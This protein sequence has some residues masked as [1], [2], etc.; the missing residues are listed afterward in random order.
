MNST[1]S[2]GFL[3]PLLHEGPRVRLALAAF[4]AL[5]ALGWFTATKCWFVPGVEV[6]RTNT[7]LGVHLPTF[8]PPADD[9]AMLNFTPGG[10]VP[11]VNA[12]DNQKL[13]QGGGATL[14]RADPASASCHAHAALCAGGPNGDLVLVVDGP[15]GGVTTASYAVLTEMDTQLSALRQLVGEPGQ[16]QRLFMVINAHGTTVI[17]ELS[18]GRDNAFLCN[19]SG[20]GIFARWLLVYALLAALLIGGLVYGLTAPALRRF[21]AETWRAAPLAMAVLVLW[22]L[23]MYAITFPGIYVSDSLL[24][25][26]NTGYYTDWFGGLY[27]IVTTLFRIIGYRWMQVLPVALGLMSWL[28]MLRSVTLACANTPRWVRALASVLVVAMVIANPAVV[29]AMFAQ[30]RY[31]LVLAV[32]AA[33]VTLAFYNVIVARIESRPMS[34]VAIGTS[35]TL[36]ALAAL[37]RTEYAAPLLTGVVL[38]LLGYF[39]QRHANPDAWLRGRM[40]I[41]AAL[42]VFFA[43]KDVISQVVP[44]LYHYD[45][46]RYA[47]EYTAATAISFAYPYACGVTPDPAVVTEV[48][49]FGPLDDLCRKGTDYGPENFFWSDIDRHH[50][51]DTHAL[52]TMRRTVLSAVAADWHPYMHQRLRYAWDTATQGPWHLASRYAL[53]DRALTGN[54]GAVS[55][56]MATADQFGLV[57]DWPPAATPERHVIGE[58]YFLGAAIGLYSF[59]VVLAATLA[60]L[61]AGAWL[62][63]AG[64]MTV[65]AMA[66]PVILAEP[67]VDWAYLAFLPVWTSCLLPLALAET[68]TLPGLSRSTVLWLSLVTRLRQFWHFAGL[69]GMGWLLDFTLLLALVHFAHLSAGLA[70]IFSSSCAA[71]CVFLLSRLII[72]RRT[73]GGLSWRLAAYLTYTLA[74]ILVASGAM[75]ALTRVLAPFAMAHLGT[76]HLMF[77]AAL[78]KIIVTPPQLVLNFLTARQLSETSL[79]LQD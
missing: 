4:A 33:G 48:E 54:A 37:L 13:A 23:G 35:L 3:A 58:Y 55:G 53:R 59:G 1:T 77:I 73:H 27:F 18:P 28:L 75:G 51:G 5:A 16:P 70:N 39:R 72:F 31:L 61:L 69:S 62:C 52:V 38:A 57:L 65:L 10:V 42:V 76:W 60:A 26:A 67:T 40:A 12:P 11:G 24:A 8:Y 22:T 56:H 20:A 32:A 71:L 44:A 21:L 30:Q 2:H 66:V 9:Q 64:S 78:T 68:L 25:P 36:L 41:T 46:S 19:M 79:S 7:A 49:R 6:F 14:Y 34:P 74:L 63:V 29:A 45:S 15:G 50:G 47:A 17:R 43:A